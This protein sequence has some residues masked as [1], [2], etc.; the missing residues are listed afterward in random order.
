MNGSLVHFFR[1]ICKNNEIRYSALFPSTRSYSAQYD[2][3]QDVFGAKKFSKNLHFP[4]PL[5][6]VFT[7]DDSGR[8]SDRSEGSGWK[9]CKLPLEYIIK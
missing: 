6:N 3:K 2:P 5:H 8:N 7:M 4:P 9:M 1:I